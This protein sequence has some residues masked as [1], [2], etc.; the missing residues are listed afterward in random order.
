MKN[1]IY[2][3]TVMTVLYVGILLLP[4][5]TS[6]NYT[7][8]SQVTIPGYIVHNLS[9]K[10]RVAISNGTDVF[11]V[12]KDSTINDSTKIFFVSRIRL[13]TKSPSFGHLDTVSKPFLPEIGDDF[14]IFTV[15][16]GEY[17]SHKWN[18]YVTDGDK[19]IAIR[20]ANKLIKEQKVLVIYHAQVTF[21]TYKIK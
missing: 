7:Q 17:Y 9:K 6:C 19:S 16:N 21:P 3:Y 14:G 4:F 12:P 15:Y 11:L 18:F 1:K 2:I 20:T 13:T 8:N 10:D 5:L